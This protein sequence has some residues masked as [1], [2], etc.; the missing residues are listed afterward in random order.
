MSQRRTTL[1]INKRRTTTTRAAVEWDWSAYSQSKVNNFKNVFL[2]QWNKCVVWKQI[3]KC[4]NWGTLSHDSK[5]LKKWTGCIFLTKMQA[6]RNSSKTKSRSFSKNVWHCSKVK[7]DN[8]FTFE[9][10][11][12]GPKDPGSCIFGI[13]S[14]LCPRRSKLTWQNAWCVR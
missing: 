8:S 5:F 2:N 1:S 9:N 11:R 10:L 7:L 13:Y 3:K 6:G 4:T 12:K 14:Y